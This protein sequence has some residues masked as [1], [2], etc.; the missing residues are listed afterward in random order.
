M[1]AVRGRWSRHLRSGRGSSSARCGAG[2]A[3]WHVGRRR[4]VELRLAELLAFTFDSVIAA[5]VFANG[6]AADSRRAQQAYSRAMATADNLKLTTFEKALLDQELR[7]NGMVARPYFD[8]K[9]LL[10]KVQAADGG[11]PSDD[12]RDQPD[13]Q[14]L[15]SDPWSG[16][17]QWVKQSDIAAGLDANGT[18][19][20]NRFGLGSYDRISTYYIEK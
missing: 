1:S 19:W 12:V 5:P 9:A 10:A 18:S 14:Y 11:F 16:G 6:Q 15:I 8:S 4:A 20:L 13:R 7:G 2:A 3:A 17:T